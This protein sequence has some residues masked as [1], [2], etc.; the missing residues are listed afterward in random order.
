MSDIVLV[1]NAGSSSVKFALIDLTSNAQP[2]SGL[3]ECLGTA[4]ASIS[5]KVLNDSG[6]EEK[7]QEALPE[8]S[9]HNNAIEKL[10]AIIT[11]NKL[12][13]TIK[14]IGHRVVHGGEQFIESV[15]IN[16]NVI[17]AIQ[18][19]NKL[20]PLHNPAN[21]QGI[22]AAYHY[23]PALKQVAVFDTAF[24]QSLPAKAFLYALP[25]SLYENEGIRRYGFH[26]TSHSYVANQATQWL[27]KNN[28]NSGHLITAHLGNGCS[29]CAIKDGKSVDTSMGFT[30]LAGIC[31]GTRSGDIDPGLFNFLINEL[32]YTPKKIETLLNKESG[33]L[34]ISQLSNDCRALEQAK[35]EGN[36]QAQLALDIFCYH[37]AKT[38]AS[39]TVPL[40]KLDALIF[41]G[42]IGENSAYIREQVV[43][44]LAIF[45]LELSEEENLNKRFGEQGC[46]SVNTG[47]KVLVIPTNEELVIAQDSYKLLCGEQS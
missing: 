21:L 13:D 18:D 33:L 10:V 16:E 44:L 19:N 23:F 42:G 9:L 8:N 1:L 20:A 38:I 5:W 27:E 17:N 35:S 31:M 32:A 24:H 26:G 4:E 41:T 43:N 2:L 36:Q 3:A 29:I 46:I 34:G 37:I 40:G 47:T 28:L 7:Q 15:L 25:Y 39:F 11:D 6:Q 30:P 12:G 14:V 45:S 22:V